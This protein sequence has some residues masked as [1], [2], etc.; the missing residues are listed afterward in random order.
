MENKLGQEPAFSGT[1]SQ[2][3]GYGAKWDEHDDGISKRFYIVCCNI[4]HNG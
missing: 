3:D 2:V 1:Y 4:W